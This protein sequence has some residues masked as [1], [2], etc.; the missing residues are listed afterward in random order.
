MIALAKDAHRFSGSKG[1]RTGVTVEV[2][3]SIHIRA[4]C[5]QKLKRY[6]AN[7]NAGPQQQSHD[8]WW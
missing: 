2:I 3:G 7:K 4:D 1:V 5:H 8:H 6:G